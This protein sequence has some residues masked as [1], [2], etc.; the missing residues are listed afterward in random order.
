ML[1]PRR[2]RGLVLLLADDVIPRGGGRGRRVVHAQVAGG[3]EQRG[4]GRHV[5]PHHLLHVVHLGHVL[6]TAEHNYTRN[7]LGHG[8]GY[9]SIHVDEINV[10]LSDIKLII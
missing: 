2:L 7:Y 1:P 3:V 5:L 8:H 4:V 9:Q 6:E 10:N